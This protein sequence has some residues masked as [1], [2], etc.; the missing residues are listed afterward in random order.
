MRHWSWLCRNNP[1]LAGYLLWL[2]AAWTQSTPISQHQPLRS[3]PQPSSGHVLNTHQKQVLLKPT[4]NHVY[5][6]YMQNWTAPALLRE[7]QVLIWTTK[8]CSAPLSPPSHTH[9]KRNCFYSYKQTTKKKES[10]SW[11]QHC[12]TW[13]DNARQLARSQ[14]FLIQPT[15]FSRCN[16]QTHLPLQQ[17]RGAICP[18]L[19]Q[20]PSTMKAHLQPPSYRFSA[21][22]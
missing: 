17:R 22:L 1:T 20:Q 9:T 13:F 19:F 7:A 8:G 14:S 15:S 10:N 16:T 11:G 6:T 21:S 2:S 12:K 18:Q 4:P 5:R 3:P